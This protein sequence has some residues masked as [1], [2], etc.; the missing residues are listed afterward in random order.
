MAAQSTPIDF[1]MIDTEHSA[2]NVQALEDLIRTAGGCWRYSLRARA[3]FA[4]RG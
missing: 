4:Q 2:T 1:V 3:R